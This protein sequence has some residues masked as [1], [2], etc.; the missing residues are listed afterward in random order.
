MGKNGVRFPESYVQEL[1]RK[2]GLCAPAPV[3]KFHN[4]ITE[5]DGI[6]FSSKKEAA[7]FRELQARQ[8][9]GEL[10]F[11]LMQVPFRLPGKAKHLLDFMAVR[12]DGQIEYI[13]VKGRDLPMG[14]LKR[15][16]VEELYGINIIVV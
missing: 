10:K 7:Q 8:H 14:K 15:R 13:E 2:R 9:L 1:M 12:T 4:K 6:R 3:S 5:A 16:Q 11:F